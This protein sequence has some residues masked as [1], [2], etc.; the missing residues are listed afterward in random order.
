MAYDENPKRPSDRSTSN[1]VDKYD[2]KPIDRNDKSGSRRTKHYETK[3]QEMDIAK[4]ADRYGVRTDA[5][6]EGAD[7]L[8]VDDIDRLRREKLNHETK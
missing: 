4:R 8:G 3:D 6:A 7:Y 1:R 5:F 2:N